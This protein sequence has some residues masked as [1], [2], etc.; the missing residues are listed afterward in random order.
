MMMTIII[1]IMIAIIIIITTNN[2]AK[3]S[4]RNKLEE[5]LFSIVR[6]PMLPRWSYV[7]ID[8]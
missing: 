3:T 6:V 8:Y 7:A 2:I 1:I 4:M 5:R